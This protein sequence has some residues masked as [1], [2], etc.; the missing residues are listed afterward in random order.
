MSL[1][2]RPFNSPSPA[3]S[4]QPCVQPAA[5][6]RRSVVHLRH[7]TNGQPTRGLLAVH[8]PRA[9]AAARV[10]RLVS[11]YSPG[12]EDVIFSTT[13]PKR[14]AA[15][16]I[17]RR[18]LWMLCWCLGGSPVPLAAAQPPSPFLPTPMLHSCWWCSSWLVLGAFCSPWRNWQT[19]PTSWRGSG[20][21]SSTARR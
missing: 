11:R 21:C 6:F 16:C 5:N 9:T 13:A 17:V 10:Q 15:V 7:F 1:C 4:A 12:H 20:P 3:S 19:P 14:T 2:F 8:R 18:V